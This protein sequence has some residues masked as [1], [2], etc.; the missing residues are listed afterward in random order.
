MA[1]KFPPKNRTKRVD[2]GPIDIEISGHGK[3]IMF[4]PN[5]LIVA[6]LDDK[7]FSDLGAPI[8]TAVEGSVLSGKAGYRYSDSDVDMILERGELDRFIRCDLTPEEYFKL[9]DTYGIFFMIHDDF[10]DE[11]SGAALQPKR[12]NEAIILPR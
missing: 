10:Y 5:R 11:E 7:L 8:P 12:M 9:R 1:D 4:D 6:L 3:A 2:L